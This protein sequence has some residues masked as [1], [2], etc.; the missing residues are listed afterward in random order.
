MKPTNI[1]GRF[2]HT[3]S[4]LIASIALAAMAFLIANLE[5]SAFI[6][7][8]P[9][10]AATPEPL[11]ELLHTS[12]NGLRVDVIDYNQTAEDCF[13]FFHSVNDDPAYTCEKQS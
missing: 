12:K 6:I 13:A 4:L 9:T 11:Y 3:D 1:L 5:A 8:T 10:N 7:E 2:V